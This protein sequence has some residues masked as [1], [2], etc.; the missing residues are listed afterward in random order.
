VIVNDHFETAL[1]ELQ[2]ILEG[3][4]SDLRADRP[5]LTTLMARLL[6]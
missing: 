6:G 1:R 4:A 5:T 3:D 2:R